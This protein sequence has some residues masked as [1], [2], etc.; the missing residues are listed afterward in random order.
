MTLFLTSVNNIR[1]E[2]ALTLHKLIIELGHSLS[3]V[4]MIY[5]GQNHHIWKFQRK[6]HLCC[7]CLQNMCQ[8]FFKNIHLLQHKFLQACGLHL[9]W[10]SYPTHKN[11][12]ILLSISCVHTGSLNI[13][14][15][16]Q[17]NG[18]RKG[19]IFVSRWVLVSKLNIEYQLVLMKTEIKIVL[20][21]TL[22]S[23]I[24]NYMLP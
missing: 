8:G 6:F 1:E 23:Y 14:K 5:S 12:Y 3:L 2:I 13:L 11:E 20:F 7:S 19:C 4:I 24:V 17:P 15:H 21:V 9:S 22:T 18:K 10:F 16:W